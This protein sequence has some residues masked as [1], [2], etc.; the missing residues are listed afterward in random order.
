MDCWNFDTET[1]IYEDFLIWASFLYQL[2]YMAS[3]SEAD[4]CVA[5]DWTARKIKVTT[6]ELDKTIQNRL[7]FI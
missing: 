2:D 3:Y 4:V 6:E 5:P 7:V 1:T